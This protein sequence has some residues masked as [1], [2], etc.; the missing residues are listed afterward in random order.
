MG[1]N[2]NHAEE[3]TMSNQ[4]KD[5]PSSGSTGAGSMSRSDTTSPGAAVPVQGQSGKVGS[6]VAGKAGT[7]AAAG[8]SMGGDGGQGLRQK[9][10]DD[11]G[12]P[13]GDQLSNAVDTRTGTSSGEGASLTG[14]DPSNGSIPPPTNKGGASA[15]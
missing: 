1:R 11:T 12:G 5:N 13:R 8:A 6:E 7:D 4:Q 9:G 2:S 15:A 10:K 14:G 3:Q